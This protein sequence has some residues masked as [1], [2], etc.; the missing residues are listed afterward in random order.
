MPRVQTMLIAKRHEVILPFRLLAVIY[1]L[2]L[3]QVHFRNKFLEQEPKEIQMAK[4]D[5]YYFRKG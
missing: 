4:I 5:W 3:L 2:V 1:L